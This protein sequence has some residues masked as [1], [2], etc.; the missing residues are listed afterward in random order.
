MALKSLRGIKVGRLIVLLL[1]ILIPLGFI[2]I[3]D[4]LPFISNVEFLTWQQYYDKMPFLGVTFC[5]ILVYF[6]APL[7]F[8]ACIASIADPPVANIG[9]VTIISLSSI[10]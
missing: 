9:S 3:I 7:F 4:I 8:N 1:I 5:K 2:F 6:F 10:S